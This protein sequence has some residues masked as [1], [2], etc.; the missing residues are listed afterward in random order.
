M[1]Y[2]IKNKDHSRVPNLAKKSNNKGVCNIYV[3]PK[4]YNEMLSKIQT[5]TLDMVA[6]VPLLTS[7]QHSLYTAPGINHWV[8][9]ILMKLRSVYR[10]YFS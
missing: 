8:S 1:F 5:S 3:V 7:C 2:I 10:F 6:D 9:K 4:L